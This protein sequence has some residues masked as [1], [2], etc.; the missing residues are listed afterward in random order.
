MCIIFIFTY[1]IFQKM[2]GGFW[3]SNG[4]LR[5]NLSGGRMDFPA[6]GGQ[7]MMNRG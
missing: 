2:A 3:K 1:F 4:D 6:Y 5:N 7:N